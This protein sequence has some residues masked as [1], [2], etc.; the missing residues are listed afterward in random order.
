MLAARASAEGIAVVPALRTPSG[1]SVKFSNG[2]P[3]LFT[4]EKLPSASSI[5]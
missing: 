5:F 4:A 1:P 2:T 3:E